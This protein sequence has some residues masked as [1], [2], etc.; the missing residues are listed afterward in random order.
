MSFGLKLRRF[1]KTEIEARV[2]EAAEI[3]ASPICWKA[4]QGFSGGSG[5]AWR[6]GVD[7]EKTQ[8]VLFDERCPNLDAKMRVRMRLQLAKLHATLKTTIIYVT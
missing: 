6:W 8:G 2:N 1:P 7:R 4:A 3:L 5:S